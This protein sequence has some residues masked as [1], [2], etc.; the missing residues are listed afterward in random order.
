MWNFHQSDA[1]LR[2]SL[3]SVKVTT[4]SEFRK[5]IKSLFRS[6]SN[7]VSDSVPELMDTTQEMTRGEFSITGAKSVDITA[8]V[9]N[10]ARKVGPLKCLYLPKHEFAEIISQLKIKKFGLEIV[11]SII[12][13]NK[14][15]IK[16]ISLTK[17]TQSLFL[18]PD[19]ADLAS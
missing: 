14:K 13:E 9:K 6:R 16:R 2:V 12:W 4:D 17:L 8:K 5:S 10:I 3:S 15:V 1:Q 11:F 7:S 18:C 19:P